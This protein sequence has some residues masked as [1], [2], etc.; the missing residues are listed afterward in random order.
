MSHT[1]NRPFWED[2]LQDFLAVPRLK[3]FT[4]IYHYPRASTFDLNCW[5]YFNALFCRAD[6]F[7]HFM[8]V[9]LRIT[10]RSSKLGRKHEEQDDL[11]MAFPPFTDHRQ[12]V[13]LWGHR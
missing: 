10:I 9:D 3:E 13:T 1:T 8:Q 2:A 7:P 12:N 11:Y 6:I 4:I 5:I